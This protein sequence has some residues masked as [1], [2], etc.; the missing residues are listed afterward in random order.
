MG[1]K[2]EATVI[3]KKPKKKKRKRKTDSVVS[4]NKLIEES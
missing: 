1:I 2:T 3:E 4:L